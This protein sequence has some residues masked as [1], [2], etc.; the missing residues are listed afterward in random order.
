MLYDLGIR[1]YVL[2][3]RLAALF[4]DKARRW[5]AGRRDNDARL[6]RLPQGK[7]VVWVHCASLGEFEQGRPLIEAL[8]ER[9]PELAILLTFFSPSGF[10]L[11]KDYPGADVVAYLPPDLPV[12]AEA[13]VAR[14]QPALAIFVK[15]EFW[16]NH[17]EALQRR[18]IPTVL[19]SARFRKNQ[20]FFRPWGG[21]FRQML[22]CFTRIFVQDESSRAL[23]RRIGLENVDVAG[24]TRVDRVMSIARQTPAPLPLVDAFCRPARHVLVCGSTWPA[25]EKVLAPLIDE[26]LPEGWKV[27]IAPHEIDEGH[28]R[29]LMRQL[30][31]PAVSYSEASQT[32]AAA[33]RVL[34][35]DNV[36]MLSR[37]YRYGR[38]AYIGGGFGRAIHNTLEPMAFG[39]PVLFGPRYEGF[40]E[41][42][43][44]V[45]SGGGRSIRSAEELIAA[46]DALCQEAQWTHS[47]RMVQ[48]YIENN[49]GATGRILDALAPLLQ[50]IK[51]NQ[52]EKIE[53]AAGSRTL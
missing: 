11:R 18:R 10:E 48:A 53:D 42:E 44:L 30:A 37:L 40:A 26:H 45:S 3:I 8:R 17:L 41:A 15:Y 35:I 39:L 20:V 51:S 49:A 52:P 21:A 29:A 12:A 34:I 43:Y 22:R 1:L 2:A 4:D 16:R 5:L 7:P 38:I 19:V 9:H 27:I 33:A 50:Q 14:V 23:L 13:F 28:V 31:Q 24:D 6:A 36:G 46:F 47:H 32:T 25:D